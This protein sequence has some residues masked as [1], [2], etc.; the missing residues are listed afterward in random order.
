M[1]KYY[2]LINDFGKEDTVSIN[3]TASQLKTA[4]ENLKVDELKAHPPEKD[5]R[6]V[7]QAQGHQ[8]PTGRGEHHL[9]TGVDGVPDVVRGLA[10]GFNATASLRPIPG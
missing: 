9:L 8:P 10:L 2:K 4:L 7:P 5:G 3:K 1:D 6:D